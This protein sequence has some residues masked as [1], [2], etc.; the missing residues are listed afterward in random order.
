MLHVRMTLPIR[1]EGGFKR[2]AA[3]DPLRTCCSGAACA[4]FA[5]ASR[6]LRHVS[7]ISRAIAPDGFHL[8]TPRCSE[9]PHFETE[10][11]DGTGSPVTG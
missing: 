4:K 10:A 1:P 2:M 3:S 11:R 5:S 9:S 7:P 6:T 8:D